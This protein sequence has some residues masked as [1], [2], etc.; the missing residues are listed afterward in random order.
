MKTGIDNETQE[1]CQRMQGTKKE[2]TMENISWT[3][4]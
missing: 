1:N 3:G 4:I 2:M